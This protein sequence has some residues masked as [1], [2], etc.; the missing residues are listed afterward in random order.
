MNCKGFE[1]GKLLTKKLNDQ[2]NLKTLN[3]NEFEIQIEMNNSE[4]TRFHK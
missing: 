2:Q 4:N 3:F 1:L